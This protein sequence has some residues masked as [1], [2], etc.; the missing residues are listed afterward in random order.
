VHRLGYWALPGIFLGSLAVNV[1][2]SLDTSALRSVLI[3]ATIAIGATLQAA[4]AVAL[5]RRFAGRPLV[6]DRDGDV[7]RFLAFGGPVACLV[8]ATVGVSALIVGVLLPVS[9]WLFNRWTW[10]VGDVIGVT[11]FSPIL[12]AFV[13]EPAMPGARGAA[14]LRSRWPSASSSSRSSSSG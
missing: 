6:L 1:W 13:A 12:L 2:T 7:L 9:G 3:A 10:W 4:V 5:V 11:V 8:G 14:G